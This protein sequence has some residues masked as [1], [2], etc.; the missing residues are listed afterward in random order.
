MAGGIHIEFDVILK[1]KFI[2]DPQKEIEKKT[3]GNPGEIKFFVENSVGKWSKFT[4]EAV[5]YVIKFDVTEENDKLQSIVCSLSDYQSVW[6][7]TLTSDEF[8]D[9]LKRCNPLLAC[10]EL[11]TRIK[12]TVTKMPK[13]GDNVQMIA[14]NGSDFQHLS[15]KYYLSDGSDPIPLKFY[16]SLEKGATKSIYGIFNEMLMK[17]SDLEK[18]NDLLHETILNKDQALG[19]LANI[20]KTVSSSESIDINSSIE[21]IAVCHEGI[22]CNNCGMDIH[23][24]RYNCLECDD[25]DLC[26]TCEHKEMQ[27]SHH[28]MVRYAQENDKNRSKEVFQAF[29]KPSKQQTTKRS[30]SS[31]H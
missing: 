27:H 1:C 7:E 15:T 4:V 16:W 12:C 8:V 30:R 18:A 10:Q 22:T 9:R 23:G 28:I 26:M 3:M 25:Y 2:D 11:M 13:N 6:F 5:E 29:S 17:I 24:N 21:V 31:R 20:Q 19:K 14:L